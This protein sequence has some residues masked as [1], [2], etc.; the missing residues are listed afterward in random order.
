MNAI[1]KVL[2]RIKKVEAERFR[3]LRYRKTR[4]DVG[5]RWCVQRTQPSAI[6]GEPDAELH[7]A[8]SLVL[9]VASP[10]RTGATGV[11]EV[12]VI[13]SI[14][15]DRKFYPRQGIANA[16]P[17]SAARSEVTRLL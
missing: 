15:I 6:H 2:R 13:T 3:L 4:R 9:T 1:Q 7:H 11:M 5:P 16:A 12:A 17:R 8:T 10:A 14:P